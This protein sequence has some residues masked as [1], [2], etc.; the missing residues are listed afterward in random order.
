ML[1]TLSKLEYIKK[2]QL[3]N[4]DKVK[5]YK[6]KWLLNNKEYKSKYFQINKK[7]ILEKK[8]LR[9]KTDPNFKMKHY[10][11]TRIRKALTGIIKKSKLT[12]D[13]IGCT[14]EQLWI[15]LEKSFK[16]GMT[17]KNYGLWHIDHIIPCVSFDLTDP[18]QQAKCFHYTNLQPLWAHENLSKGAKIL[19]STN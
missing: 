4:K 10:L 5:G 7:R 3:N 2:W 15:H 19:K 8:Y 11:G 13:L 17:R 6:K 14:V 1:N 18:K 9:L 16:K 12:Q